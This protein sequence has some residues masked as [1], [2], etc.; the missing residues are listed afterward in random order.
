MSTKFN[1]YYAT[2]PTGP[3]TLANLTPL[4]RV[5]AVQRYTI[6][7][8]STDTTY[9]VSIVGGVLDALDNF[10]PLISQP[11][12]PNQVGAGDQSK[13]PASP[14]AVRTFSPQINV[15]SVLGHQYGLPFPPIVREGSGS[16]NG[17]AG[18]VTSL[19]VPL[20]QVPT[21]GN[22]LIMVIGTLGLGAIVTSITQTG[23]SWV[24][25]VDSRSI[26]SN[27][28]NMDIWYASNVSGALD[29]AVVNVPGFGQITGVIL[30]YSGLEPSGVLDKTAENFSSPVT[31]PADTGTTAATSQSEELFIGGFN[32]IANR[33]YGAPSNGFSV[34]G[35][36]T[37]GIAAM[38]AYEKIVSSVGTAGLT[39]TLTATGAFAGAVA[40]FKKN[41]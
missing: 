19:A 6:T 26:P 25:A 41:I 16:A 12:G 33:V 13:N 32:N 10:I 27:N 23:A 5:E 18:A 11:I 40:T 21:D 35:A 38:E 2:S 39:A 34:V 20:G 37:A 7:G 1:I 14:I 30:E 9:Y 29:D 28:T 22:T 24:K 17:G 15:S 31:S 3:W 36:E 4:D 8:L